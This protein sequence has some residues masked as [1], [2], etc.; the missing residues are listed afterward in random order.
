VVLQHNA[1]RES[2][3]KKHIKTI[4]AM[5]MLLACLPVASSTEQQLYADMSDT[6][7]ATVCYDDSVQITYALT[8]P[9][10]DVWSGAADVP[11]G[12]MGNGSFEQIYCADPFISFHSRADNSYWDNLHRVT[13]DEKAGYTVAAPWIVSPALYQNY[14]AV[15]WIVLNGYRGSYHDR[16]TDVESLASTAQ[17]RALYLNNP[18]YPDITVIDETI[19][20]MATKLA[21]WKVLVGDSIVVMRTSL[22]NAQNPARRL[23]MDALVQALIH[24]A[25]SDP[26]R[27]TSMQMTTFDLQLT[28]GGGGYTLL[29]TDNASYEIYG[30]LQVSA[31]L[32]NTISLLD[33][34]RVYLTASGPGAED[35]QFMTFDGSSYQPLP[36]SAANTIYGTNTPAVYLA[37]SHFSA[38][39]S[40]L[41]STNIYLKMPYSRTPA[42]SDQI[43]VHAYAMTNDVALTGGTPVTFVY[44]DNGVM[45]WDAVQAFIGAANDGM[46]IDLYDD[47]VFN[48]GDTTLGQLFLVK[49]IVNASPLDQN[50]QFT[51]RLFHSNSASGPWTAVPLSE[52]GLPG[53]HQVSGAISVNS[54]NPSSFT[55]GYHGTVQIDGLA[56]DTD[57]YYMLQEISIPADFNATPQYTI[58]FAANP[59]TVKTDGSATTGFQFNTN[60]QV[61]V[62]FYNTRQIAKAHLYV[63]KAAVIISSDGSPVEQD[64]TTIFD[65]Q[66]QYSA[67]NGQTW[68]AQPLSSANFRSASG[69][70]TDGANGVFSLSSSDLAFIEL[71]PDIYV[72]RVAEINLDPRYLATYA[73]AIYF[74]AGL[75]NYGSRLWTSNDDLLWGENLE[76]V[77]SKL[78]LGSDEYCYLLFDNFDVKLCDLEISKTVDDQTGTVNP[79]ELYSFMIICRTDNLGI[80]VGV[81]LPLYNGVNPSGF[82]V[83]GL[84]A[85]RIVDGSYGYAS[86]IQLK[87]G[88]TATVVGL[89]AGTYSVTEIVPAG[90]TTHYLVNN[91]TR[92]QTLTGETGN[93]AVL[94]DSSILFINT[95]VAD[96]QK[97]TVEQGDDGDAGDNSSRSRGS[98]T[99]RT[100][101]EA[102]TLLQISVLLI[103]CGAIALRTSAKRRVVKPS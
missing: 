27:A 26:Q 75:G 71:E 87:H 66:L 92:V 90:F 64:K 82:V 81:P 61:T 23:S 37:P 91:G 17:L 100:G 76:Y 60:N 19:A 69:T 99:A 5:V 51:F 11:I 84:P 2:Y 103:I 47:A 31:S 65:F 6:Y 83:E 40:G 77:T 39:G 10:S 38:S 43:V 94:D 54:A 56:A 57:D 30:S 86:L 36:L 101:D 44:G 25:S 13:V 14:D 55:T 35:V 21:V 48:T 20:L 15:R 73:A 98:G 45:N 9:S 72:Y 1:V 12:G 4:M 29:D 102:F 50:A 96:L 34:D 16:A 8:Y 58:P 68:T 95:K 42:N 28:T 93:L 85:N 63:G 41:T 32:A 97:G 7:I 3:L 88:E 18:S 78:E 62:N 33:L 74:D 67:D 59:V 52:A 46:V 22:D 53:A 24:D 89:P 70:L 80:P 79:D 49:S